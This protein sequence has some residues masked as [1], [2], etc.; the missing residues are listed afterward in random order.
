MVHWQSSLIQGEVQHIG[1]SVGMI[2]LVRYLFESFI[3]KINATG[4]QAMLLKC[5]VTAASQD[6]PQRSALVATCQCRRYLYFSMYLASNT[7]RALREGRVLVP[8]IHN[9]G[10]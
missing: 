5:V 9:L 7:P 2:E 10:I 1:R 4:K 6:G 8:Q 3:V